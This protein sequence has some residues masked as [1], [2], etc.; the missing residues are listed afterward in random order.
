MFGGCRDKTDDGG[1]TA[2]AES[3]RRLAFGPTEATVW[4]SGY[5][6]DSERCSWSRTEWAVKQKSGD[7][8]SR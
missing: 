1:G 4:A 3:L 6:T 2:T 5:G 8:E 7:I